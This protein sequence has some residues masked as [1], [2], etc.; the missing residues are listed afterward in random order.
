MSGIETFP[1]G[2]MA[3]VRAP[4]SGV[5]AMVDLPTRAI[6]EGL[7]TGARVGALARAH[8]RATGG[9]V[10]VATARI[11]ELRRA[12]RELDTPFRPAVPRLPPAEEE[13]PTLD[14]R[15][16]VGA[17]TVRLRIWPPTL[18]RIV[19]AVTAPARL[20]GD[21]TGGG[22]GEPVLEVRRVHGS[23]HLQGDGEHLLG[24]DDLM[25]ARSEILRWLIL[26]S[27]PGRAW[28]AVL[29]AAAV[30]GPAGAALLCGCSGAGKS[31]LT[32]LLLASGLELVTDDYA[33]LEMGTRL[34]W[35]VPFGLSAKE[36]SWPILAPYF[37][38][39]A[40]AP[41]VR[42]RRRRQRYLAPPALARGPFPAAC[43]VFPLYQPG[44]PAELTRLEPAESL[45][46]L[47]RSGGWY[48]NSR[49]RLA[50]LVDWIGSLPAYALAY[51]NGAQAVAA[52]RALIGAR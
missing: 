28:L 13:L 27:H 7:A 14:M 35:P 1:L 4:R 2:D 42:T 50:A 17:A 48:E 26:A 3:L 36:G 11:A 46:L 34:I 45:Q 47:T 30:A 20:G 8:A 21:G 33:P 23:Y 10:Q 44:A 41:L 31:T 49:D 43:L 18:A 32:G 37:P 39:L 6:L 22:P 15:C 12:W 5:V 9:E 25:I 29:H 16:R 38:Q 19:A 52:V 51:G 24:T 40:R